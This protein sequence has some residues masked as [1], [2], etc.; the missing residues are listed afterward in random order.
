MLAL[1]G[2]G[3][4]T[5]IGDVGGVSSDR[6]SGDELHGPDGGEENA[7]A[8]RK[9]RAPLVGVW[10]VLG[11]EGAF[12]RGLMGRAGSTGLWILD[13]AYWAVICRVF[14]LQGGQMEDLS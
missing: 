12:F 9:A 8:S 3:L 6:G 13:C 7:K 4:L 5:E 2:H 10:A 1:T 14:V 11:R